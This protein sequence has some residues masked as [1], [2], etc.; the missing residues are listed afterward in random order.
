MSLLAA[1]A[2]C[3]NREG[4]NRS[5]LAVVFSCTC[6]DAGA[7]FLFQLA[8]SDSRRVRQLLKSFLC[9]AIQTYVPTSYGKMGKVSLLFQEI[10]SKA[11]DVHC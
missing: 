2:Q 8:A 4:D 10:V 11:E 5:T 1:H 9:I 3:W 6:T 7:V